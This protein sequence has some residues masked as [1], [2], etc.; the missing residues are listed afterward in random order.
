MQASRG[1][2][3]ALLA[4]LLL[5]A[6]IPDGYMPASA[7]SGLLFE[8]CP[9]GLPSDFVAALSGADAYAHHAGD[10]TSGE[11]FSLEHCP[12]GQLL[13]AAMAVDT[14]SLASDVPRQESPRVPTPILRLA[15]R[16][17]TQQARGPPA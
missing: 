6:A 3:V 11:H 4:A 8:L 16:A 12:V 15:T 1:I 9:A 5:R 10:D 2:P 14:E 7:G 13:S 17:A